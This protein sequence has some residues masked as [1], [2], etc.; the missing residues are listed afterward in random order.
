MDRIV[1]PGGYE[2]TFGGELPEGF[3][4]PARPQFPSSPAGMTPEQAI[5]K[6]FANYPAQQQQQPPLRVD[7]RRGPVW[8]A[9]GGSIPSMGSDTVPAMLTPGE[10]IMS[11]GAVSKYGAGFM[12]SLNRGG[13]QG[14]NKGGLVQYLQHGSTNGPV[15]SNGNGGINVDGA[16]IAEAL[17]NQ[18]PAI[19]NMMGQ[20]IGSSL[21]PVLDNFTSSFAGA[22]GASGLDAFVAGLSSAATMFNTAAGTLNGLEMTC[23]ISFEGPLTLGG[24]DVPGFADA[25]TEALGDHVKNLVNDQLSKRPNRVTGGK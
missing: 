23:N 18:A 25:I 24:I 5:K 9:M 15:K 20:G 3:I 21:K 4:D 8:R 19:G 13:I 12:K 16:G 14:Y 1:N 6:M 11:K 17:V 22:V 7:P 2:Q 10:F